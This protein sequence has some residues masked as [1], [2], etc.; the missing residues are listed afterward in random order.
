M[1]KLFYSSFVFAFS[2]VLCCYT[3]RVTALCVSEPQVGWISSDCTKSTTIL[4]FH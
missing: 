1:D 3:I 2:S 4:S